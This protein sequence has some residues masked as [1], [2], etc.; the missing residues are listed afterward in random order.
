MDAQVGKV[1]AALKDAGLAGNT[2]VIFTSDHGYHLG[3][4]DFWAKVSVHEESALV[5]LIIKLPGKAPAVYKSMVE[6]LDLYPTV[7]SLC[8]LQVPERLQGRNLTPIFDDPSHRVRDAVLCASGAD[9]AILLREERWAFIQYGKDASRGV[10]LFDMAKDPKQYNNLAADPG[11]QARVVE[12]KA[13]L[14]AKLK[15]VRQNDLRP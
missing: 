7:S 6:L 4:H 10:E 11:H 9:K 13:K 2:I 5:P 15:S 1:L 12:L 14:A 8:G 3:E